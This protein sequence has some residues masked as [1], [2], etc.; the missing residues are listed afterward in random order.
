NGPDS[1]D[2]IV[3]D[4]NGGTDIVTVPIT[5]TPVNDPPRAVVDTNRVDEDTPAT[6]N[7]L[8]ND[9]DPDGDRLRVTSFEVDGNTYNP[10]SS[11]DIPDIGTITIGSDGRYTFTPEPNWNGTVPTVTYTINDGNG[12]TDS[13]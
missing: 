12:G 4:G 3:D 13:S 5:V 11:A 1:F 10:G 7:V 8:I 9:S 6:G 2:V